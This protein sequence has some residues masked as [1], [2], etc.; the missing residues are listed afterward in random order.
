MIPKP[1]QPGGRWTRLQAAVETESRA[2]QLR[3]PHCGF[4]QSYWEAGGI[5]YKG[6]GTAYRW[7]RCPNCGRWGWEKLYRP[8]APAAPAAPNAG[9]TQPLPTGAAPGAPPASGEAGRRLM[10]LLV[11]VTVVP[12]LAVLVGLGLAIALVRAADAPVEAAG[13]AFL[14]AVHSQQYA[15][16]YALCPPDLQGQLGGVGGLAAAW[17]GP[18]L[19]TWRWTGHS[20]VN[21]VG[22]LDGPFTYADGRP[23]TTHLTLHQ[24][25]GAWRIANFQFVPNQ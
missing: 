24:V 11:I 20:L 12:L 5:I 8:K 10:R 15:A 2:W 19:G 21:G 16:A 23:G 14:T 13:D 25:S 17:A 7:R 6:A 18:P 22:R 4:E 3:C 1:P 9:A